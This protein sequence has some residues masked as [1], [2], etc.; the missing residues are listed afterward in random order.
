MVKIIGRS[1]SISTANTVAHNHFNSRS[2]GPNNDFCSP[3]AEGRCLVH[4]HSYR[5]NSHIHKNQINKNSNKVRQT[6]QFISFYFLTVGAMWLAS[7][8]LFS[9]LFYLFWI[10]GTV[11]HIEGPSSFLQI[12][13][14]DIKVSNWHLFG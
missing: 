5:Q 3:W 12:S 11:S 4:T 6:Q 2:K 7:S 10:H 8:N 13:L 1:L 9:L 14:S